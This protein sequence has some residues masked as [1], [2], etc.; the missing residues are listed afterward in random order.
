MHPKAVGTSVRAFALPEGRVNQPKRFRLRV[1][2]QILRSRS[3]R[4]NSCK[5]V[6]AIIGEGKDARAVLRCQ[7]AP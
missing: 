7:A 3:H 5:A 4:R 1:D 6:V 2:D